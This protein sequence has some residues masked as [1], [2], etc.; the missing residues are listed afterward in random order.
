MKDH[1]D[2]SGEDEGNR[3]EDSGRCTVKDD[4]SMDDVELQDGNL[5]KKSD[6]AGDGI[7]EGERRGVEDISKDISK[8]RDV[9]RSMSHSLVMATSVQSADDEKEEGEILEEEEVPHR[10]VQSDAESGEI[11]TDLLIL[12]TGEM[13]WEGHLRE[14]EKQ[15][16]GGIGQSQRDGKVCT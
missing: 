11:Q 1:D 16:S 15:F 3:K 12:Q 9:K 4:A 2:G 13:S 5:S 7:M 14:E 10:C 8:R 6:F